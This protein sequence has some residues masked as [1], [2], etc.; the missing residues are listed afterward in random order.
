[1]MTECGA[2]NVSLILEGVGPSARPTAV[3]F[4]NSE[5]KAGSLLQMLATLPAYSAL[6]DTS[7]S[8]TLDDVVTNR[9]RAG[10]QFINRDAVRASMVLGLRDRGSNNP[11]GLPATLLALL[12]PCLS[13]V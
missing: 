3:F 7:P 9:A 2:A 11:N 12:A 13:Y 8:S 5:G 6:V 10:V 1:M 4:K